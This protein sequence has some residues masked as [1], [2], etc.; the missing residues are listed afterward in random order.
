MLTGVVAEPLM[1]RKPQGTEEV[2]LGM[3]KDLQPTVLFRHRPRVIDK[4]IAQSTNWLDRKND[5][6]SQNGTEDQTHPGQARTGTWPLG[7]P[8]RVAVRKLIYQVSNKRRV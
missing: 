1:V 2:G 4:R 3:Q 6:P 8:G 5:E 7:G